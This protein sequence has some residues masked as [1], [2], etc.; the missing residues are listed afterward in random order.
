MGEKVAKYKEKYLFR[1]GEYGFRDFGVLNN[2]DARCV[3]LFLR[4]CHQLFQL[5]LAHAAQTL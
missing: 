3:G 4:L 5:L 2:V 1:G